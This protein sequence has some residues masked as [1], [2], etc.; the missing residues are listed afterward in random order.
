MKKRFRK[1]PIVVYAEQ[2]EV[3]TIIK[4]LEGD[5]IASP[6]DWIITGIEGERYPCKDS[7]FK[8]TYE[9]YV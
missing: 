5:M 3:I 7:I 1:K 8:K 9:E 2:C 6:G 4:T